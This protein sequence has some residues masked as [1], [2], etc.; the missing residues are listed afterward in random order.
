MNL[1]K[2]EY[3]FRLRNQGKGQVNRVFSW[4]GVYPIV[5]I[6]GQNGNRKKPPDHLK[7]GP[8]A[9]QGLGR[10]ESCLTFSIKKIITTRGK[11]ND[12]HGL[13]GPKRATPLP[14]RKQTKRRK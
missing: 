10:K 5:E 6:G 9:I 8:K 13:I 7:E 1:A 12:A 3:H 4:Q 14:A 11:F 2:L